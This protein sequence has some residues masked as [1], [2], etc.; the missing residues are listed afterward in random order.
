MGYLFAKLLWFVLAAF[1]IGLLIGW[2][3]CSGIEDGQA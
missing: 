3:T 1:V 2:T